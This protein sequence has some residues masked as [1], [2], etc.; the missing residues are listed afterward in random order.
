MKNKVKFAIGL[1]LFGLSMWAFY[2]INSRFP[3]QTRRVLAAFGAVYLGRLVGN[4][5][6]LIL[7]IER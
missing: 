6:D 4:L 7:K 3:D 1:V 5:I 2:A